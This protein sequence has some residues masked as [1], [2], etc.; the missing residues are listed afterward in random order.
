M[1]DT[2]IH[3]WKQQN[4]FLC[5]ISPGYFLNGFYKLNRD[6]DCDL[7]FIINYLCL[8][9]L[10]L[11]GL[12]LWFVKVINIQVIK[13]QM[14]LIALRLMKKQIFLFRYYSDIQINIH[15]ILY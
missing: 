7:S 11:L 1:Y 15:I 13:Q 6:F 10:P 14:G 9:T 5:N 2:K 8:L 12:T 3:F 4:M